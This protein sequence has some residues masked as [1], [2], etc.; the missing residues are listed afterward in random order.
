MCPEFV[1]GVQR[2]HVPSKLGIEDQLREACAELERRL[3]DGDSCSARDLLGA[4]PDLA[5]HKDA[6]LELIYTEFVIRQELGETPSPDRWHDQFPHWHDDLRQLFQVHELLGDTAEDEVAGGE[7]PAFF[8][9]DIQHVPAGQRIGQYE[10]LEE[11]G[12][13]GMGVVYRACQKGLNRPVALKMIAS[14]HAGPRERARFRAEAEAAARLQHPNIVQIYEVGNHDGCPYL[15]MELVDGQSLDERLTEGPLSPDTSAELVRTLAR[16]VHAAHQHGIVHRDLKPANILL[17]LST[18]PSA[19]S[20]GEKTSDSKLNAES[21][22]L[23]ACTPKIADFG[24]AKQLPM[25]DADHDPRDALTQ[26]GAVLGTPSYMTPEQVDAKADLIGPATDVYALG[27]ILYE[28]VTGRVPFRADAPLETLE[29]VRSQDPL[30]PTRLEPKLP[31]DLETICL[32]CLQKEPWE[33]YASAAL[34]AD[35][36]GRFL[37][38]EAIHARPIGPTERLAKW[39]RRRPVIAALIAIVG[40]VAALGF[41]GVTWQW[42][43][44]EG[45]AAAAVTAQAKTELALQAEEAQRERAEHLLYFHD[46]ALA[47]HEYSSQN[48]ARAQQLLDGT[49]PELRH[50]EWRYLYRLCNDDLCTMTGH[51]SRVR[52]VCFSHDGKLV[53]SCSGIWGVDRPGEIKVWDVKSGEEAWTLHGHASSIMSVAFS[54]DGKVLAS[55]GINW[56]LPEPGQVKLWDMATGREILTIQDTGN[57]YSVAF[58]PDGSMLGIGGGHVLLYDS[59]SWEPIEAFGSHHQG[60]FSIAFSPDSS[61]IASAGTDGPVRVWDTTSGRELIAIETLDDARHVAFSPDGG[62]LAVGTYAGGVLIWDGGSDKEIARF[63]SRSGDVASVEFSPDARWLAVTS[64]NGG[65]QIWDAATGALVRDFAGHTGRVYSATFSP[66]GRRLATGGFDRTV[67]LWD[68][69]RRPEPRHV[70]AQDAFIADMAFSPDGRRLALASRLNTNSGRGSNEPHLRLWDAVAQREVRVYQGHQGWLTSVAY[71]P[72]GNWIATGSEDKTVKVW[73]VSG[74]VDKKMK[75]FGFRVPRTLF[76]LT[77][78]TDTVTSVTFGPDDRQ[79]VSGSR[80]ETLK[81]WNATTGKLVRTEQAHAGGVTA[82]AS[83][84]HGRH[85]VSTGADGTIKLWDVTTGERLLS[86]ASPSGPVNTLAV[87]DDGQH[88]ATA[89]DDT[90]ICLWDLPAVLQGDAQTTPRVTMRGH[91]DPVSEL[92]FSPDGRRL[93]STSW[94]NTIRLWDV[95]SGQEVIRLRGTTDRNAGVLFSPDGQRL[96]MSEGVYLTI[97]DAEPDQP[98]ADEER[99]HAER[100]RALEWHQRQAREARSDEQTLAAVFHFSQAVAILKRL[101]AESPDDPTHQQSLARARTRLAYPLFQLGRTADSIEQYRLA[102]EHLPD[103][104]SNC[105]GLAWVLATCPEADLRDPAHAAELAQEA[106]EQN[107]DDRYY[108]NTLGVALYRLGKWNDAVVALEAAMALAD[109]GDSSDW[110]ILAMACWQLDERQQADYWYTR[111]VRWMQENTPEDEQLLRFHAEAKSLISQTPSVSEF[112]DEPVWSRVVSGYGHLV[113][114]RPDDSSL[115]DRRAYVHASLG[116]WQ[117]CAADFAKALE[118]KPK[119][120]ELLVVHAG[121]LLMAGDNAGYEKACADAIKRLGDLPGHRNR[122]LAAKVCLLATNDAAEPAHLISL[123]EQAVAGDRKAEYLHLLGLAYCRAGRHD[124][125]IKTLHEA[126]NAEP[127]WKGCVTNWLVL[128]MAHQRLDDSDEAHQWLRKA[129]T[130]VETTLA[131]RPFT[132]RGYYLHP[133]DWLACHLL[134]REAKAV[135]GENAQH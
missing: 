131:D 85:L 51:A 126:I 130:W 41:A 50:W 94:D 118:L 13:G 120:L 42:Q 113:A 40:I 121:S 44:A 84:R 47:F 25:V 125:A 98:A 54:P 91:Y 90:L 108:R 106:V 124:K 48:V 65:I 2:M 73:N 9:S 122:Y 26:T 117:E 107:R 102:M 109:G 133:H 67:K 52:D 128:A 24:L 23:T 77:G 35:D 96:V 115:Y 68:L 101:I 104:S 55:A 32:K 86:F 93:V 110:F 80:D 111:A 22:S 56:W 29:Q 27:V 66:Q 17:A 34:L 81:F 10:V 39:A 100:L 3:R 46:I 70:K 129:E 119:F 127:T 19:I 14:P 57:V 69:T 31:R 78:H 103:D 60:A 36:L 132:A 89:S 116:Q 71:S 20:E 33:R 76:T 7:T 63:H 5:E 75:T 58:S 79:L 59:A 62:R 15:A 43:R 4:F 21:F 49:Q 28:A 30:P 18:Q 45:N 11:L 72:S 53:A 1:A 114:E 105:N 82:L 37:A 97:W 123:A 112:S 12:H 83:A 6:A 64:A 95:S 135:I 38:G 92:G 134:L 99:A 87:S 74:S 8:E 16:A 61:Q 88:L